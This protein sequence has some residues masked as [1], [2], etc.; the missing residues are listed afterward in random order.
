MQQWTQEQLDLCWL[1][2]G[3]EVQLLGRACKHGSGYTEH[4][5]LLHVAGLRSLGATGEVYDVHVLQHVPASAAAPAGHPPG[6]A[7]EAAGPLAG[8]QLCLKVCKR[9]DD[10]SEELQDDCCDAATYIMAMRESMEHH[11]GSG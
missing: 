1:Q 9:Y 8:R 11:V 4:D 10:I 5:L 3:Q 7:T 2:S 6:A